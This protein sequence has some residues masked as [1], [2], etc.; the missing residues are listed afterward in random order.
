M[1]PPSRPFISNSRRSK[2]DE[3]WM[4]MLGL[5]VGTTSEV[6]MVRVSKN[7]VRMSLQLEPT[8]RCS[9]GAPVRRAIQPARTL[10]KFPVGTAKDTGRPPSAAADVA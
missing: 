9:I 7:R 4:S 3:T 8:I 2:L 10:P 1:M 6:T 5:N